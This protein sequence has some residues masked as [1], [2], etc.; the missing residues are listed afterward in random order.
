MVTPTNGWAKT[1]MAARYAG[2]GER[3]LRKWFRMGLRHS[4]SPTGAILVKYSDLDEFLE[5]FVVNSTDDI[6]VIV[7]SV[8]DGVL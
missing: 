5:G 2:V 4:K 8:L 7:N 6:D 1:I 3:T